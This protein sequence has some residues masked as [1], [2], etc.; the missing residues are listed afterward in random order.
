[1]YTCTNKLVNEKKEEKRQCINVMNR[2]R[3]SISWFF[4]RWR[5]PCYAFDFDFA[6]MR[7]E[8]CLTDYQWIETSHEVCYAFCNRQWIGRNVCILCI[9]GGPSELKQTWLPLKSLEHYK[10]SNENFK[11]HENRGKVYGRSRL[12]IERW[13]CNILLCKSTTPLSSKIIFLY[14]IFAWKL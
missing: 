8:L 9:Y 13:Q 6:F 10:P 3:D 5:P 12:Y 7:F 2:S 11:H 14:E 4:A 1:M